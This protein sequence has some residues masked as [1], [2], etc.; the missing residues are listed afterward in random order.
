MGSEMCIRDRP[1]AAVL[2]AFQ[3]G[4]SVAFARGPAHGYSV[5]S[6]QISITFDPAE[7]LFPTTTPAALSSATRLAVQKAL[8]ENSKLSETAMME[9]VMLVTIAVDEDSLGSVVHDISSA[10]GGSVVSLGSDDSSTSSETSSVDVNR[11][12]A[13]PDP[14]AGGHAAADI[15]AGTGGAKNIVARVPLKEMVGY[16]KHLRSLTGGRGTFTMVVDRF[17]R[18]SGQRQKAVLN[19]MRGDYG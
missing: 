5:H 15:D 4:A 1:M 7:H 10:R 12:Y 14:F 9:P 3:N 16:L 6:T 19:E 17:E 13:P 8:K 18:M 2:Q 11:I